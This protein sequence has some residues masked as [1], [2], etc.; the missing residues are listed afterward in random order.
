MRYSPSEGERPHTV[1][2]PCEDVPPNW[3]VSAPALRTIPDR[4]QTGGL[5]MGNNIRASRGGGALVAPTR[6]LKLLP[7]LV[8]LSPAVALAQAVKV[9]FVGTQPTTTTA[10][11]LFSVRVAVQNALGATVTTDNTSAITLAL[12]TNPC[13]GTLSG[14]LSKTVVNGIATFSDLSIDKACIG[15]RLA[16][17]SPGLMGANSIAFNVVA[18][19]PSQLTFTAQPTDTTVG[20]AISPAVQ[21]TVQDRFK[22]TVTTSTASIAVAIDANPG[23]GTLSGT[24]TVPAVAGVATFSNLS[25]DQVGMGYTLTAASGSL[26]RATSSA[27]N[28][29]MT[30]VASKLAFTVQPTSATAGSAISPSVQVT[31]QDASGN[32]VTTST[33][34]ITVAIGTNPGGG[35][36]SG[37]T[38]VAAVNGVATFSNLSIDK[39]GAGY[40]LTAASAPLTGATSSAFN[41]TPA[42][43]N[44]LAFAQQPSTTVAGQVISP[45]V[46]VRVVDA[47]G[48][49]VSTD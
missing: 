46:T 12:G 11:A 29:G 18:A 35:T 16:A 8:G 42:A 26:T 21:V 25:I 48:N 30:G 15:Y 9:G 36:L 13:G 3:T 1:F 38:T 45:A 22:N 27:F 4:D 17:S 6:L 39:A 32:T 2:A 33:A 37:T 41:I 40:T 43:A 19:A 10:G 31:V 34:I 24:T 7:L 44:H 23:G 20:A 47:F 49:L 5:L 28:I 14:T